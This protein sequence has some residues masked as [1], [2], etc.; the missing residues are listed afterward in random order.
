MGK[1]QERDAYQTKKKKK[2]P[3]DLVTFHLACYITLLHVTYTCYAHY[4]NHAQKGK[5]MR[6]AA[7]QSFLPDPR[8]E[9]KG[10]RGVGGR[11][12]CDRD[13]DGC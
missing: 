5:R 6:T 9:E 4:R 8:P 10:P 1:T 12:V 2:P 11:R 13:W 7:G 3:Q